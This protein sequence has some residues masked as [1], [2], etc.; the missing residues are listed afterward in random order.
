MTVNRGDPVEG[1]ERDGHV[2]GG[3]ANPTPLDVIFILFAAATLL[4]FLLWILPGGEAKYSSAPPFLQSMVKSI[5]G[6]FSVAGGTLGTFLLRRYVDRSP[7][8]NYLIW[9][10]SLMIFLVATLFLLSQAMRAMDPG[11]TQEVRASLSLSL[12]QEIVQL[13]PPLPDFNLWE[14]LPNPIDAH[15][16]YRHDGDPSYPYRDTLNLRRNGESQA[17]IKLLPTVSRAAGSSQTYDYGICLQN[18]A[19]WPTGAQ[20]PRVVLA[21]TKGACNPAKPV[22]PGYVVKCSGRVGL[23]KMSSVVYAAEASQQTRPR[24]WDVPSFKTLQRMAERQRVGYT[25]FDVG[26]QPRGRAA[27]SDR[28]YYELQVNGQ[29]VY[30][31]G[32]SPGLRKES[33]DRAGTNHLLFALENL[34]FTGQFGGYEHLRLTV[35]FL[36]GSA[37][38]YRQELSRDYAA[39]RDT[40]AIPP[41]QTEAGTFTWD[42][43]YIV[44]KNENKYEILVA[45]ADCGDPARKDCVDRATNAK[46]LFDRGGKLYD[47]RQVVM[48]VRPPLRTPAAYGLALGLV[49]P[50]GQVQFTFN[51]AEAA[52]LCHWAASQAGR[53][54]AGRLIQ[55]DLRRYEVATRGYAPCH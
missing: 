14:E 21:C 31:D 41:I 27:Q 54:G 48:V 44:P 55:S 38:G 30:I 11:T 10:P 23:S 7:A 26:F 22:D 39:L 18:R 45:S 13:K 25:L 19:S 33:L 2:G 3:R 32:L 28:Y 6:K 50:T 34:N 51:E 35:V 43:K 20:P 52:D 4:L 16:V 9:I 17:Y 8:P 12:D 53:S 15:G 42:G 5:W 24:G 40:T 49:Q 36:D 29:P 47:A 37:E 46:V 1:D